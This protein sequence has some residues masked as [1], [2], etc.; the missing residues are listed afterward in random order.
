MS[1]NYQ[2]GSGNINSIFLLTSDEFL[3]DLKF[4]KVPLLGEAERK[5]EKES[6]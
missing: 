3:K 1:K 6:I 4:V 2:L 5:I